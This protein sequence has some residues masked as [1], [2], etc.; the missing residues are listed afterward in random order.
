MGKQRENAR[1][2]LSLLEHG[3][4]RQFA[5]AVSLMSIIPLLAVW[6]V[7]AHNLSTMDVSLNFWEASVASAVIVVFVSAGVTILQKY[8]ANISKL[9]LALEK[10]VQGEFPEAVNLLACADDMR[11]IQEALNILLSRMKARLVTVEEEKEALEKQLCQ[12]QKL[13]TIGILAAG[14]T[15]E[16]N[17][18]MQFV[19]NNMAFIGQGVGRVLAAQTGGSDQHGESGLASEV[20]RAIEESEEGLNQV[21]QIAAA[22]K[23]YLHPDP[24]RETKPIDINH[25]VEDTI[26][27]SRN[28]WKYV[29]RMEKHVAPDLPRVEGVAGDIRQALMN[30]LIN[31]AD[32]IESSGKADGDLGT[33]TVETVCEDDTVKIRISDTGGGIPVAIREHVFD[34]FFTTKAEGKGTGMGL[35]LART[36]ITERHAGTLTFHTEEGQGTTFTVVLPVRKKQNGNRPDATE[37]NHQFTATH[38]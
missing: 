9:R 20:Q 34:R 23:N 1:R 18:P 31:A 36:F 11:A 6:A 13:E 37:Q 21:V 15:H 27:L 17:A 25:V 4:R 12:A 19:R 10:M 29:A 35:S 7:A 30:L 33:I 8:P 26:T 28:A 5:I 16:I 24:A 32:A 14:I 2:S 3:S 38:M 22:M